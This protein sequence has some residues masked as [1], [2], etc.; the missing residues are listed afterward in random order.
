MGKNVDV[1]TALIVIS[2]MEGD[3]RQ[4]QRETASARQQALDNFEN[5]FEL[6]RAVPQ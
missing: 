3:Y 6:V 2:G 1:I 5:D 4:Q